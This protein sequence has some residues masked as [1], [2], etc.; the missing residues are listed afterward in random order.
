MHRPWIVLAAAMALTIGAV[1]A[2]WAGKYNK[3]LNIGDSAPAWKD[4]PGTDGKKHSLADLKDKEVVVVVFT[5]NSCPYAVDVEDRLIALHKELASG[6]KGAL[7]AVCSNVYKDDTLE[8]MTKRAKEKKF[9][10]DYLQ[11]DE[12]SSLA[13]ALG[14]R[15]TPEFFVLDKDRNVVYMGAI[16]DSPDGQNVK[17]KYVS[18]AVA[19][20]LAG[21]TPAVQ[22][23]PPVGC[24]IRF[25]KE[26]R[27]Q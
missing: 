10:F 23:T 12:K 17:Q 16:D 15:R 7:V 26:R 13:N 21:K 2:I 5:C 8:A 20:V 9:E 6:G 18:D 22:E 19:A 27:K 1:P 3:G 11:D 4:L 25:A 24:L 14:A